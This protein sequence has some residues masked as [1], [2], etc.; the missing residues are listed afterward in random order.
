MRRAGSSRFIGFA[1]V[2]L[3]ACSGG[4][5]GKSGTGADPGVVRL[6][7]Y[8]LALKQAAPDVH[9]DLEPADRAG[10]KKWV[11]QL[12]GP[13]HESEK[14]ALREL[15]CELGDYLPDFAFVATMDDAVKGRVAKLDFVWGV[16]RLKPAF[17]IDPALR[18][19]S[20]AI[21]AEEGELALTVRIDRERSLE[22]VVSEVHLRKGRVKGVARRIARIALRS[23]EIARIAQLEEVLWIEKDVPYEL[24]N[25]TTSWVVQA[26]EPGARPIWARGLTGETEIIGV[27]DSGLDHDM[28]WFRDPA[29]AAIGPGH[30]KV[31]GY[32]T[33]Y[34]DDYDSDAPGHGTH[35]VGTIAGDRTP[36]DGLSTANGMAPHARV[37]IND[38]SPGATNYVYPPADLGLMFVTARDAG[39]RLHTNSWGANTSVY[40]TA[41]QSA[42]RFMWENREFL[43]LFANGNAGGGGLGTVGSPANAKNVVSVGATLNGASAESVTSFSSRGPTADGRIKPTVTAPG[44]GVVERAGVVSADSDGVKGSNNSGTLAMRG[45]SMA[46]PA[47]AGL[48]ALVRQYFTNGNYPSGAPTAGDA[49]VPSAALVKATL[50]NTAR[51]MT[52]VGTQGPIPAMG[53]GW[54]RVTLADTLAFADQTKGLALR[55]DTFGLATGETF[56]QTFFPTGGQPLKVTVVWTDYPGTPGAAKALVN[57]LDL[58]VSAPDG[59][60]FVGNVFA[61]GGSAPGGAPDRLNVEEQALVL[62][63]A[64]GPYVVRVTGYNVPNGPQPFALV[65]SGAQLATRKG[66]ATLDRRAYPVPAAPR[67]TVIDLDLDLDPST[68]DSVVVTARSA[69]EPGGELVTLVE[70]GPRTSTFRASFGIEIAPALGGDGTLQVADGDEIT[71]TYLDADDGTG[72]GAAAIAT[73]AVDATPPQL[74]HVSAD[75]VT[76]V[77]ARIGWS[78]DEPADSGVLYGVGEPTTPA[79]DRALVVAH[80]VPLAG[81]AEGATYLFDVLSADEA[82]NQTRDDAGGSHYWFQTSRLP[83]E[84]TATSSNGSETTQDST[85]VYGFTRDPSGI[86]SVTV[87]G[88]AASVYRASDG[89]YEAKVDLFVGE[90]GITVVSTDELGTP[91]VQALSVRRRPPPDFTVVAVSGPAAVLV[92]SKIAIEDAVANLGPGAALQPFQVGYYL[93]ADAVVD[94]SDVYLGSRTVPALGAGETSSA[95]VTFTVAA[96][97]KPGTYRLGAI[98]DPQNSWYE[99]SESN[100]SAL[101]HEVSVIGAD[102]SVVSVGGPTA[103]TSGTAISVTDTVKNAADAAPAGYFCVGLYL[104]TDDRIDLGTDD[105][106]LGQRCVS[107]LAPG[108]TSTGTTQVTIPG[109]VQTGTY[110]LGAYADRARQLTESDE[111]NNGA[112]GN[113]IDLTYVKPDYG[114][115]S[116]S[117][118]GTAQSGTQIEVTYVLA[119]KAG[120]SVSP[121]Q[122]TGV[123]LSLDPVITTTDVYVGYSNATPA[124]GQSATVTLTVSV[125]GTLSGRYYLGAIADRA[126]QVVESDET[127]NAA[128]GNALELTYVKPDYSIASVSGPATAQSGTQIQ[129]TYVLTAKAGASVSPSQQ[130]GVYLS[131]DPVITTTDVFVAYSTATPATGQSS[132]VTLAVSVPGTLSGRYYLGAI[133]DRANQVAESDETNNAAV[134]GAIDLTYVKPDYAITSVSGPDAAQSGTQIQVTYVLAAKAGASVSPSQQTGVYLS[135]D[136]VVTTTDLFIGYSTAT[137]ATGQSSTVTLTVGVPGTLGG[138]YYLGAIADRANQ[139]AESDETNNAAAGN[140]IDLTYVA[141]DFSVGSVSGPGTAQSGTQIQ[142]T[143]VVAAKAGASVSPSQQT[144]VY[145]SLDPIVTTTDVFVGYSTATPTT[146]KSSAVTLTVNV[147]GT[148]SGRYYLGVIADRANQ[149]AESDETNNAAV[150]DPIDL[151]YVAPDFSVGPVSGPATAQSGTPIEVTYVVAAKGG[152][153][154]SPSQ[155]AG[156]YLSLDPVITTT[157][158]FVA[159]STAT[160]ATGQSSTV[161]LAVNVP[162]T[163]SGRYYLGVIADRSNQVAESDEANNAAVG[164]AIDLSYVAPDFSVTSVSGPATAQRGTQI[165][166]TYVVAAK[167]GASVSPSQQTGVYLSLDPEITTTDVYVGYGT[168]TP[169]T[170]QSSTVTVTVTV[171]G[172]LGG[173]Y[174]F[175]AIADRANQVAESDEGNNAL[176]GDAIDI[177]SALAAAP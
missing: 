80:D 148:L 150:G 132:T 157:D 109:T 12:D 169:V 117:G 75:D 66:I 26:N 43:A 51:D 18:D 42:D 3:A 48:A 140:A 61:G 46:T 44:D 94:V 2:V 136:P 98:A 79:K 124:T 162:G 121:P 5:D 118:P 52:G 73:A 115:A 160:P 126:N 155:Q 141:P 91:A 31:V 33:T 54:G 45:T 14:Q 57:D 154:V 113:A 158:V 74:G 108:A 147:P 55:D 71:I 139:V 102:L 78:T 166:V 64:P 67:V 106:Y 175:G 112:V 97:L 96:N 6:A 149:V 53:Q 68:A 70:T 86:R 22:S 38:I 119:A 82:G 85:M 88:R 29:G 92:G 104:S 40:G 34:G 171:P 20:G 100:N 159:Y 123:Y 7:G 1:V 95:S 32:D 167:A 56:T 47:V 174:Y 30:R 156:V 105:V 135:F 35:V 4:S 17:K 81:L 76:D 16:T 110:H 93:S 116:V 114:I 77:T 27:G 90:N 144:G 10:P 37:F 131:V 133:A 107:S 39:A 176:A 170:G 84:L 146:G 50:V 145:L 172:T 24:V 36:V 168:A 89:Y 58:S 13:V 21:R 134:G 62:A 122:Q 69:T 83:P 161:K 143:Y 165:Q 25:D 9:V 177:V 8:E 129:V 142:V 60:T 173:R 137:P 99:A 164:N 19:E 63:P 120:A 23:A 65:V 138:R 128:A 103:A 59:T 163:L 11:V 125:P 28:P 72:A 111:T 41:S 15:G 127:N 153:S 130:A 101:G 151:S 87:N 152:A 49:F